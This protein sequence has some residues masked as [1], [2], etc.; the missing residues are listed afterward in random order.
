MAALGSVEPDEL[1]LLLDALQ[2]WPEATGRSELWR[3]WESLPAGNDDTL[4]LASALAAYAP[5]SPGWSAAAVK[6]AQALVEANPFDADD[7]TQTC[8]PWRSGC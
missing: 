6:V 2:A 7:W 5:D 8:S 3:R 1:P 4:A